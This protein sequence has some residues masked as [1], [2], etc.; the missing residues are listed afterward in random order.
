MKHDLKK[1]LGDM[2]S[3]IDSKVLETKLSQAVEMIKKG[4]HDDI[5]KKF[6]NIDKEEL[7]AK[8]HEIENL[9]PQE[10]DSLRTKMASEIK[11]D[12]LDSISQK[13][14]S[15]GKKIFEKIISTFKIK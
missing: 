15:D 5:I 10:L 11:K 3:K 6:N 13:L 9:N 8:L 4:D 2:L 1:V 12:D 7:L 14:G